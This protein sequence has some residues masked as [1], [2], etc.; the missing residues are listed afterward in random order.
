MMFTSSDSTL[1]RNASS[2]ERQRALQERAAGECDQPEPITLSQA[3]QIER[4]KFRA[5]KAI[6]LNVVGQHALRSVDGDDKVESALP[7]F[8]K[9]ET[10]LRA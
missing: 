6:R 4:G 1:C 9:A 8:F 2:S 10:P 7:G 5:L 3:H